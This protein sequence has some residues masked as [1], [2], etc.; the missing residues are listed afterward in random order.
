MLTKLTTIAESISTQG[1]K[2]FCLL[3]AVGQ[4]KAPKFQ[5]QPPTLRLN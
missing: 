3:Q 1:L 2:H 4:D 5:H